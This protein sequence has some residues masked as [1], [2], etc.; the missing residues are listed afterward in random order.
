MHNIV[1]INLDGVIISNLDDWT[2]KE[3]KR[4]SHDA[5]TLKSRDMRGLVI[6]LGLSPTFWGQ[7][8]YDTSGVVALTLEIFQSY[9]LRQ[10]FSVGAVLLSELY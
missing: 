6:F 1:T 8:D 9:T 3:G 2:Q 7:N 4:L 5:E 10:P